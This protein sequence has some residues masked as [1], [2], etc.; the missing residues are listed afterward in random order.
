MLTS[1]LGLGLT[2]STTV[3]STKELFDGSQK[4]NETRIV[5]KAE[6]LS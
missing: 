5:A 1:D 4:M 6:R 2:T 3:L